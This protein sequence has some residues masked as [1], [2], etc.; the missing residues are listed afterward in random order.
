MHDMKRE[1]RRRTLLT[2]RCAALVLLALIPFNVMFSQGLTAVPFLLIPSS[3]DGNGMGGI[4]GSVLTDN[5]MAMIANPG[6]LGVQ[7][8]DSYF[9]TAIYA[10]SSDWLR[11]F[12]QSGLSYDTKALT[13][14]VNL[15]KVSSFPLPLSVGIGYSRIFLNLGTFNISG[16]DPTVLGTF[17]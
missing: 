6:Q 17:E 11:P 15:K 5:A 9:R 2:K 4:N 12:R 10:P 14:G 13:L 7:S 3:P 16:P 8:L 1:N